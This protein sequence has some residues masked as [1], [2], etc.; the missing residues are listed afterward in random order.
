MIFRFFNVLLEE[1]KLSA[2]NR[3]MRWAGNIFFKMT[4]GFYGWLLIP[5][6]LL[7]FFMCMIGWG[8]ETLLAPFVVIWWYFGT[9][10]YQE[11]YSLHFTRQLIFSCKKCS[12]STSKCTPYATI[13]LF[14]GA[15]FQL[16]AAML[17]L[18]GFKLSCW[19]PTFR[20]YS[21]HSNSGLIRPHYIGASFVG[22]IISWALLQSSL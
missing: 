18:K 12:T 7:D 9:Q 15:W 21:R 2:M 17:K 20:Q 19:C 3:P 16:L 22:S 11:K 1:Q 10:L 4:G 8:I 5:F 13:H 14:F 6:P